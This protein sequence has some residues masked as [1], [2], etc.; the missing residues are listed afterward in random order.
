[1]IAVYAVAFPKGGGV[2]TFALLSEDE[3]YEHRDSSKAF[4]RNPEQSIWKTHPR[5]AWKKSAIRELSKS[6]SMATDHHASLRRAAVMDEQIDKGE[7]ID[8]ES[9]ATDG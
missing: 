7:V 3:V 1:M 2:P 6:V 9:E 5:I 8:V 4:A